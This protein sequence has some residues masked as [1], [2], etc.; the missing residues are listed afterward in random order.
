MQYRESST[1]TNGN[2]VST[3]DSSEDLVNGNARRDRAVE[4][5]KLSLK[6]LWN[7]VASASRVN[8]G[9]DHL[10]VHDV[11]ELARLLQIV[12]TRHLHQLARQLVRYLTSITIC[13][14]HLSYPK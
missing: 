12:E 14:W 3:A 6:S 4:N 13:Y 7:I 8:H 10:Y 5:V 1:K 2:E 11:C 9:T